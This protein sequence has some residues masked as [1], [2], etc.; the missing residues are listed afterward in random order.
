MRLPVWLCLTV[1]L[2]LYGCSQGG[3]NP[4][5]PAC[6]GKTCGDDGCG[7]TCGPGCGE[8]ESCNQG[9]CQCDF[10]SCDTTCCAETQVCDQGTCV[11]GTGELCVS[12]DVCSETCIGGTCGPPSSRGGQCDLQDDADCDTGLQC[13]GTT[14]VYPDGHGCR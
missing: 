6:E 2:C 1:A 13:F 4:C 12:N 5:T 11:G 9:Q 3:D 7:N 14:C 10:E 8:H